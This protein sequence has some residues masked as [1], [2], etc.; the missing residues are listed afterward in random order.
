LSFL[1]ST[2]HS[3]QLQLSVLHLQLHDAHISTFC[4]PCVTTRQHSRTNRM[5]C[6]YSVCYEL[7][8]CTRYMLWALFAHLQEALYIQQF[9]YIVCVLCQL[10]ASGLAVSRHIT[11]TQY[12]NYCVCSASW[13]WARNARNM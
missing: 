6:L 10:A 11:H 3:V 9:V 1:E 12:T 2:S 13:W 7:T 4:W 8:A 5:H